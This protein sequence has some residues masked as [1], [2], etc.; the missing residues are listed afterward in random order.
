MLPSRLVSLVAPYSGRPDHSR[1]IFIPGVENEKAMMAFLPGGMH[2]VPMHP[3]DAKSTIFR[4]QSI[5]GTVAEGTCS[6]RRI[7]LL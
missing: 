2:W 6:G 1:Q 4:D 5:P 7:A 3:V